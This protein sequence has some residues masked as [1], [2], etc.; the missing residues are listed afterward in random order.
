MKA[1]TVIYY[2]IYIHI[3][4]VNVMVCTVHTLFD[5]D[6]LSIFM[7]NIPAVNC[8]CLFYS[9]GSI[10]HANHLFGAMA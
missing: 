2:N 10:V 1:K 9:S 7:C 6:Y 3:I 4:Q 8:M 5:V